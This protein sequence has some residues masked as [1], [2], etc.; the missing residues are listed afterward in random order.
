MTVAT[1][2]QSTDKAFTEWLKHELDA[3]RWRPVDLAR[4]SGV[5]LNQVVLV[6]KQQRR[7]GDRFLRGVA[8]AFQMPQETV[9]RLAGML[10]DQPLA[11]VK[12]DEA[13]RKVRKLLSALDPAEREKAIHLLE[14]YAKDHPKATSRTRTARTDA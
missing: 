2:K 1:Q 10:N 3:R 4:A 13:M 6:M 14:Q 12:D 11:N 7:A 8:T 9:F 5:T